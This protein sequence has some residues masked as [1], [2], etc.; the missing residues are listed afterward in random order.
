S[1]RKVGPARGY[2]QVRPKNPKSEIQN[3]NFSGDSDLPFRISDFEFRILVLHRLT[4]T[5]ML[6]E[7]RRLDGRSRP[8]R[9]FDQAASSI[10]LSQFQEAFLTSHQRLSRLGC[11]ASKA[12]V[13]QQLARFDVIRK[14]GGQDFLDEL[15]FQ[16]R[17]FNGKN[18]LY[19]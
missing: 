6:V 19:S 18:D 16:I 11:N 17:L 2:R 1:P 7:G 8:F 15:L 4:L 14:A 9:G 10:L 3:P 5:L 12:A 13:R